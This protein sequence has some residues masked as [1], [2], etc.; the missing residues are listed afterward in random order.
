M[1]LRSVSPEIDGGKYPA[2][3]ETDRDFV[4][5]VEAPG[6][7]E[8]TL[9][10][11]AA[12][13]KSWQSV[14]MLSL[15]ALGQSE[16]WRAAVRFPE[17]GAYVY[18]VD[19]KSVGATPARLSYRELGVV[20][21]SPVARVGAWYELFPRSQGG[22]P[23]KSGTFRD[24]EARLA[25]IQ[26]MGFDVVY[27]APIHPIGR[28]NRKGPNNTL[29][30]GP[31]DPGCVWSIGDATGGHTAVH[32]ELGTLEDFR[33]FAAKAKERGI[34]LALDV[35]LTCSYD[36]PWLKQH[37]DWFFHNADGSIK[38]AENPPKKYEDTVFL[39]FY[40]PDRE[41]MWDELKGIFTFWIAQGVSIFRI[42]NPHTKPDEFW[43]WCIPAV[44]AEH[45]EAVFLSEAFTYFERL[46]RLAKL[47]FSQSYT[48]F[49]WR[50]R[51]DEILE[52]MAR[53][54]Q[55]YV[56][57]FLRPNFFANTP[58]ILPRNLQEGG[59]PAFLHRFALAATLAP[60][61]GIYSNFELC[62]NQAL[63]GGESYA[64][65]EKYVCKV[66]DWDRPGNIKDFI[67]LVN[68]ARRE[69]PALQY[70]DGLHFAASTDEHVLAF[71]KLSPDRSNAVLVVISLDPY[72]PRDSRVTLPLERLGLGHRTRAVEQLTGR[73][74]GWEGRE[75]NVLLTQ[76]A[77]AQ[78]YQLGVDAVVAVPGPARVSPLAEAHFARFAALQR[79]A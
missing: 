23:G 67:S 63:A 78:I 39:N 15:E 73:A 37:P 43:A 47:G 6:A 26:A 24:C 9:K 1:E 19:A 27:L 36:H 18:T 34:R 60:S 38:Y 25:D 74:Y 72:N 71:T 20:V 17:A 22:V 8:V 7:A 68:R 40:P 69:N 77:P 31:G 42:D 48:Y 33:R 14:P 57:D 79:K 32:P 13:S 70:L 59:R 55:T 50:T 64:D 58:D 4:V 29:W 46:E 12:G 11:R 3:T 66:W 45:P 65:S 21:D 51:R 75:I 35:A 76:N 56:K 61:Y 41:R 49:T 53:L 52:Y 28:T 62:E 30:A 44:K 5:E 54:T 2:K 16:R 10:T